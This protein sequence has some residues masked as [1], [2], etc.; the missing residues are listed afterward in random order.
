MKR[1]FLPLAS[2]LLILSFSSCSQGSS[3]DIVYLNDDTLRSVT[4]RKEAS[5]QW[6]RELESVRLLR[7]VSRNEA[8]SPS[9]G[10]T[11]PV[12]S[13]AETRF[14]GPSIY[15]VL[16]GFGSLDTSLITGE[17][18][19]FLDDFCA[20]VSKWNIREDSFEPSSIFSLAFFMHDISSLWT[21]FFGEDFPISEKN[22]ASDGSSTEK[23]EAQV[24]K[25]LFSRWIYGEP[26]FDVDGV[27]LPVRFFCAKGSV[28]VILYSTRETFK[29]NQIVVQKW[30]KK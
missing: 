29:L 12:L 25:T 6:T 3:S 16:P 21:D 8:V 7:D 19:T 9:L 15:P 11:V 1:F 17:Y 5:L 27:H 10:L 22:Q 2:V 30:N 24:E 18:R 14:S 4:S 28:D 26:F 23:Q 20:S 13:V